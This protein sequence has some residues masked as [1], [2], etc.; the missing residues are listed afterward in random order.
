MVSYTQSLTRRIL[1]SNSGLEKKLAIALKILLVLEALAKVA[2]VVSGTLVQRSTPPRPRSL[3]YMYKYIYHY[4]QSLW[5]VS[6]QTTC[7]AGL[8]VE[9]H[10]SYISRIG[11]IFLVTI[12]EHEHLTIPQV[13]STRIRRCTSSARSVQG[14]RVL[15]A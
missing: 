15:E 5:A 10:P 11:M 2:F 12:P 13:Y 4:F 14:P 6:L 8:M 9:S 7:Y 3:N 1:N